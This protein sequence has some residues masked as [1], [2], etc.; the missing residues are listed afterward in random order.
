MLYHVFQIL[1]GYSLINS[2][3]FFAQRII[4]VMELIYHLEN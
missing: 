1:N 3:G 4:I 2:G